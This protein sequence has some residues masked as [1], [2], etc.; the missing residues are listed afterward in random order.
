MGSVWLG[1]LP[2]VLRNAGLEVDVFPGW[3]T[4]SRV[5]GGYDEVRAIQAHH[6]ASNTTPVNDMAYMWRNAPDRPIGACYLSRDGRWTV[7]A[8]GATNTS[9]RGGPLTTSRGTIPADSANRFVL[10]IEAA[11]RGDGE[12]WSDVQLASY[13]A[14]V[15]ALALAY[16]G[17]GLGEPGD[18]HGHHE[19]TARKIDPAGQSWYASGR[20]KWDMRRFRDDV[21]IA[22]QPLPPPQ[23]ENPTITPQEITPMLFIAKPTFPGSTDSDPWIVY[24]ANPGS[25]PRAERATNA[26]VKAAL[27]LGV[28]VVDQDSPDQYAEA[29]RKYGI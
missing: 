4:R 20:N 28:P 25:A 12:V 13:V 18:V 17:Q 7:G 11:N 24:Y 26:H 19:W 14:G 27:I 3:E 10:S 9:G 21:A 15:S 5:T 16:L 29:R 2:A 23:P 8:A 22:G 6:T 1:S